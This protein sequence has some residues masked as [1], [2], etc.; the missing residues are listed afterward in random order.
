[1]TEKKK[2]EIKTSAPVSFIRGKGKIIIL[3]KYHCD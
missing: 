3:K 1:L 2:A